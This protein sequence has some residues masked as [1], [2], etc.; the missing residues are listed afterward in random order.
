MRINFLHWIVYKLTHFRLSLIFAN[1]NKF[2]TLKREFKKQ[3]ETKT[4]AA[5]RCFL[6][7][8]FFFFVCLFVCLF[9][10]T[11][12]SWAVWCKLHFDLPVCILFLLFLCADIWRHMKRSTTKGKMLLRLWLPT[13]LLFQWAR[14]MVAVEYLVRKTTQYPVQTQQKQ[15][16]IISNT[17]NQYANKQESVHVSNKQTSECTL[18]HQES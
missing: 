6:S 14:H 3:T 13:S 18:A 2:A 15:D 4:N 1:W 8:F 7:V 17:W 11:V 12:P 16:C 9:V 5:P 10:C